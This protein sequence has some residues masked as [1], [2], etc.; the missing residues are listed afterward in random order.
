MEAMGLGGKKGKKKRD[1]KVHNQGVR[2]L[3]INGG[4]K[5]WT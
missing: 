5:I 2:E 3:R 1:E 4:K